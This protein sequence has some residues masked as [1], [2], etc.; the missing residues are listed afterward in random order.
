M[1]FVLGQDLVGRVGR[2]VRNRQTLLRH[3][4]AAAVPDRTTSRD[5]PLVCLAR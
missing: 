4:K 5:R 2:P 1:E 3:C